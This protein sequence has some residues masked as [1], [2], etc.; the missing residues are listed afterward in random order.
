MMGYSR[1][2][3]L[4]VQGALYD[5]GGELALREIS[6]KKPVLKKDSPYPKLS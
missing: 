5:Q 1:D 6:R 3:L 4:P 2:R